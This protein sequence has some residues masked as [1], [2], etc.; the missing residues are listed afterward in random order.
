MRKPHSFCP[1]PRS[2]GN[3]NLFSMILTSF[4]KDRLGASC[5][6]K[7]ERCLA[8]IGWFNSM[9]AMNSESRPLTGIPQLSPLEWQLLESFNLKSETYV[10][11]RLTGC[12]SNHV[13]IISSCIWELCCGFP[14]LLHQKHFKDQRDYCNTG[15]E[16]YGSPKSVQ[17]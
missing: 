6:G 8:G 14:G 5:E 9:I 16:A 2:V 7:L 13:V 17:K 12:W 1:D 3:T 11:S 10:G 4:T 15:M